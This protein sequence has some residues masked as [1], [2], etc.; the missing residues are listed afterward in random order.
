MYLRNFKST[1]IEAG[2]HMLHAA[3]LGFYHPILKK[4]LMFK[5]DLPQDM[6]A[7]LERLTP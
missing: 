4:Q 6:A 7:L 3:E 5:Q 1:L 2:R